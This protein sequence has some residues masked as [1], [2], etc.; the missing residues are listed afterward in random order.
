MITLFPAEGVQLIED[1]IRN[2]VV[3]YADTHTVDDYTGKYMTQLLHQAESRIKEL[4]NA[5]DHGR[6]I[7]VEFGTTGALL[8]LQQILGICIPP[9]TCERLY[10]TIE[11]S[12][13]DDAKLL[14]ELELS[15]LFLR[16]PTPCFRHIP[17][18]PVMSG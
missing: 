17:F 12:A 1:K 6:I 13:H 11:A 16:L 3:S 5:G 2:I 4:V 14:E 9:V 15:Y 18:I 10:R 7:S 8:K